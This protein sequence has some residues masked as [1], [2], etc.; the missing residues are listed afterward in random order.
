MVWGPRLSAKETEAAQVTFPLL[1]HHHGQDKDNLEKEE[2]VI[3]VYCSVG[4]VHNG[5]GGVAAG[6]WRRKLGTHIFSH[7]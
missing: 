7:R 5:R 4:R 2:G 6:G 1:G 3:W